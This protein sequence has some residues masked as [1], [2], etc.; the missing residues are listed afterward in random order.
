MAKEIKYGAEA[1]TALEA[2]VN[3]LADT[4]RVTLGP[5]GRN[6]VL[7]KQFGAPLITNDGVTIA[8]EIELE[9]AFENM[10][11]QLIKEVASKTKR[12]TETLLKGLRLLD[13]PI[14]ITQQYTK[15][16]GMSSPS[17]FEAAGTD[18][19]LEKRTF[20]CLG[21]EIIRKT[22]QDFHKKQ[23][24]VCGVEAHICV[25]QT[26]LDL[27]HLGYEVFLIA[28]CV[29]SRKS[30]DLQTAIRRM[31]QA[32]AVVTSYEAILFELMETSMH[33]RFRE[34]SALIK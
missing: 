7:D 2:G 6:V 3:K 11:A 18:S 9:D 16:L 12:H 14:L 28:D 34:I 13:I 24:I 22:L 31:T 23:V 29:S 15:G 21:D 5:K 17:L 20:S 30:S 25:E 8:K 33:P 26:V 10:G 27:L 32:G 1:R 19:W 4:V